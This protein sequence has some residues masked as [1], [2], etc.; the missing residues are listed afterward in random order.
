MYARVIDNRYL[1]ETCTKKTSYAIIHTLSYLLTSKSMNEVEHYTCHIV[2]VNNIS[3]IRSGPRGL[4]LGAWYW[5]ALY[6][7]NS[8]Q[9]T[10][11]LHNLWMNSARFV[12]WINWKYVKTDRNLNR[13]VTFLGTVNNRT[14][15]HIPWCSPNPNAMWF[16]D[17]SETSPYYKV[18]PLIPWRARKP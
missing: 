17:I 4:I 5:Y 11:S 6:K 12:S 14:N 16:H 3:R 1:F 10:P 8:K 15:C 13:L 9:R 7:F 2:A 18:F